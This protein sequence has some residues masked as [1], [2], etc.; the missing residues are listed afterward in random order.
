MR[1]YKTC[2]LHSVQLL[3]NCFCIKKQTIMDPLFIYLFTH[4]WVIANF[5][6]FSYHLLTCCIT[7]THD[8]TQ[9]TFHFNLFACLL[10]KQ[11]TYLLKYFTLIRILKYTLKIGA[12][13]R[14]STN[15][16]EFFIY[17]YI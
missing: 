17:Y 13:T 6:K 1:Q 7:I 12:A 4:L 3:M 16:L 2:M 10:V 9:N 11:I 5:L 15:Y 8:T 14:V